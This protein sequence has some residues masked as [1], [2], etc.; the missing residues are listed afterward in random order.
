[1]MKKVKFL[2]LAVL[3]AAMTLMS[4][5]TIGFVTRRGPWTSQNGRSE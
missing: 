4:V 3:V 2:V 1:M 5:G